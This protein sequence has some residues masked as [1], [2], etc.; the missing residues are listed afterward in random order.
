M[1]VT[2]CLN[3][4]RKWLTSYVCIS[5]KNPDPVK[6][7]P[8]PVKIGPDP[9]KIGPDPVKKGPD[10]VKIGADPQHCSNKRIA[11]LYL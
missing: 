10:P 11:A 5:K 6:I 8:D 1:R 9:V 7:G 3:Q 2:R 4:A